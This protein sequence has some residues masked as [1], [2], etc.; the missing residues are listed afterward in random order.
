M[1]KQSV[2]IAY[3]DLLGVGVVNT[4]TRIINKDRP[5]SVFFGIKVFDQEVYIGCTAHSFDPLEL[6]IGHTNPEFMGDGIFCGADVF[7]SA[8]NRHMYDQELK[9]HEDEL[10][11]VVQSL[12]GSN[13]MNRFLVNMADGNHYSTRAYAN[14]YTMFCYLME[15]GVFTYCDEST[16]PVVSVKTQL[17]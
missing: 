9:L 13:N 1:S 16:V 6:S 7:D 10:L 4:I 15:N 17:L 12:D 11:E 3:Q 5:D 14:C 8:T 2:K